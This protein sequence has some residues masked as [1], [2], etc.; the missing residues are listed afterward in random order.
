MLGEDPRLDGVE[1]HN[2]YPAQIH[3]Y[4]PW[5]RY[6]G[7]LYAYEGSFPVDAKRREMQHYFRGNELGESITL[8]TGEIESKSIQNPRL[9]RGITPNFLV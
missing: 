8:S 4:E 3:K 1:A 2:S 7:R 6:H 9:K 5:A